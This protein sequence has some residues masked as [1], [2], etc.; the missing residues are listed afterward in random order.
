MQEKKIKINHRLCAQ[1]RNERSEENLKQYVMSEL[2]SPIEDYPHV[3]D[4]VLSNLD[5]IQDF[6]LVF[7]A[8]YLHTGWKTGQN[9]LLE[10]LNGKVEKM[11]NYEKAIFWYL[12]AYDLGRRKNANINLRM[13]YL[14]KSISYSTNTFFAY[15]RYDLSKL[16]TGPNAQKLLDEARSNVIEIMTDSDAKERP[17]EYWLDIQR[18]LDEFILGISITEPVYDYL[19][20]SEPGG[21]NAGKAWD[22]GRFPAPR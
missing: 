11:T 6:R 12:N 4:L 9:K 18:W 19:Y 2:L 21:K 15:N 14:R 17:I 5:I 13:E 3:I 22:E 10:Y 20:G 16:E 8:S 1:F 7:I